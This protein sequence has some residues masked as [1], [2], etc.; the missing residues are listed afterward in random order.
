[1]LT[2]L[3]ELRRKENPEAAIWTAEFARMPFEP[4]IPG[5]QHAIPESRSWSS[6]RCFLLDPPREY[7][8][9]WAPPPRHGFCC[10]V[11]V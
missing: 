1:M 6:L 2:S 11:L 8:F 4:K 7:C 3:P 5:S 9:T 10:C